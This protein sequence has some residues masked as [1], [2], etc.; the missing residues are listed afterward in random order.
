MNRAMIQPGLL[1]A[2]KGLSGYC[3]ENGLRVGQRRGWKTWELLLSECQ[4]HIDEEALFSS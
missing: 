1:Y 4:G 3:R 2:C